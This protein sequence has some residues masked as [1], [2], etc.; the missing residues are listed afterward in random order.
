MLTSRDIPEL[1]IEFIHTDNPIPKGLGEIP[2]DYP[3]PALRNA[4]LN[5][6]GVGIDEI[7]LTPEKIFA[8][9]EEK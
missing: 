2:M 4:F 7:P 5:A 9:L 8:N 6:T 1:N 3:A